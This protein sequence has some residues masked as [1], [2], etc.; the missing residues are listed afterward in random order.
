MTPQNQ[1]RTAPGREKA[2]QLVGLA[3]FNAANNKHTLAMSIDKADPK[4][5]SGPTGHRQC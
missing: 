5:R 4:Q 3:K 2:V 1:N